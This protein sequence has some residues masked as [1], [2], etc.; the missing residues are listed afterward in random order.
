MTW[1]TILVLAAFVGMCGFIAY[2]GDLLGRRMGKRRLTL[3]GLR[4]RYTAILTTSVTGMMIAVF[5][6]GIM[7]LVSQRVRLL[8]LQ[9]D[10]IVS[11]M[12]QISRDYTD[13]KKDYTIALKDLDNQRHITDEATLGAN[14][15]IKQRNLLASE[16]ILIKQNLIRLKADLQKNKASLAQAES[17]LSN[18]KGDLKS[19]NQEISR[20]RQEIASQHKEIEF[21]DE[22]QKRLGD[23]LEEKVG[24]R[25]KALRERHII[26]S[27]G[28]EIARRVISCDQS[29]S[30]IRSEML[31]LLSEA[32][33]NARTKGAIPGDNNTSVQILPKSVK[34][35]AGKDIFLKDEQTI[36]AL[37]D[38]IHSA[39]G[40]VVVLILSVGN[41]VD[42]EQALIEFDRPFHNK[43]IYSA[44]DEVSAAIIDGGVSRGQIL[45]SLIQF[46]RKDVRSSAINDGIIPQ[47]DEDGQ[48][49]VGQIDDWDKIF[50]LVDNIK[51]SNKAVR[52]KA[53]AV[54]DT[55]S[56]GPLSLNYNVSE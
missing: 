51:K 5:T 6:I 14:R 29:K 24:P 2:W 50:D 45:S 32:D 40:S 25:L 18:T 1:R 47:L 4:P 42:G 28:E 53:L 37:V 11:R 3:F 16:I 39:V 46:L 27:P 41:S 13:A 38:N 55:W 43:L 48:P 9:G 49:T 23:R 17:A 36:N 56:A 7:A 52:V 35:S 31:E 20:K 12:N 21:L 19:A 22:L 34:D 10:Q 8:M 30:V 33:K 54:S 26:F 15:A 44:G